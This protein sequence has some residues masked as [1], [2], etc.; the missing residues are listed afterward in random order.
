VDAS[1][2]SCL[3]HA[4][5]T[6]SV[7]DE[8][9]RYRGHIVRCRLI[10]RRRGI[11]HWGCIVHCCTTRRHWWWKITR[12]V[13]IR[14]ILIIPGWGQWSERVPFRL[15]HRVDVFEC[16]RRQIY[17]WWMST[18]F[19]LLI[20]QICCYTLKS[21]INDTSRFIFTKHQHQSMIFTNRKCINAWQTL[22]IM[23]KLCN[24]PDET[25]YQFK[26]NQ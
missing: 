1:V 4:N 19:L 8:V 24:T 23:T 13:R 5:V 9:I 21:F 14:R 22:Q 26:L 20:L 15:R 10:V 17:K 7:V 3:G 6:W 18:N 2:S 12:P 25:S 16:Q 11:V